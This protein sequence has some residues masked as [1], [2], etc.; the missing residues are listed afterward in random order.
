[1]NSTHLVLL[2]YVNSPALRI[3]FASL[4]VKHSMV[5]GLRT[6]VFFSCA[7]LPLTQHSPSPCFQ[8]TL[9][10]KNLFAVVGKEKLCSERR[11][12]AKCLH[13]HIHDKHHARSAVLC[14]SLVFH[15][16]QSEWVSE[17]VKAHGQS[18]KQSNDA[19]IDCICAGASSNP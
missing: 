17:W 16:T 3:N 13:E 18:H 2:L 6:C 4:V 14:T 1:M 8:G 11:G 7:T 5:W 12:E 10:K 15:V 9:P 19:V